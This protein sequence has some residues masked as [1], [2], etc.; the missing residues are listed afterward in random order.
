MAL[1]YLCLMLA[2][3]S[4]LPESGRSSFTEAYATE[5]RLSPSFQNGKLISIA[6]ETPVAGT[7]NVFIYAKPGARLASYDLSPAGAIKVRIWDAAVGS[8]GTVAGVGQAVD[9]DGLVAMFLAIVPPGKT[10]ASIHRLNPFTGERVAV[11]SDGTV[12][13][14]SGRMDEA[15]GDE[16]SKGDYHTLRHFSAEGK[17]LGEFVPRSSLQGVQPASGS[18]GANMTW[19]RAAGDR[20]GVYFGG[21]HRWLELSGGAVSPPCIARLPLKGEESPVALGGLALSSPGGPVALFQYPTLGSGLYQLDCGAGVWQPLASHAA[22]DL[23]AVTD[24]VGMEGNQ[25]VFRGPRAAAATL[26]W[27]PKPEFAK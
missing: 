12:W 2:A 9:K 6:L 16:A 18:G 25:L 24:L 20:I 10:Q 27:A 4:D 23:Q 21:S 17:L 15:G 1:I 22:A 19:L 3:A 13:L 8:S 5:G 26:V 7:P 11:A 14:T